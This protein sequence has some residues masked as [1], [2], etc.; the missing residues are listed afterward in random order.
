MYIKSGSLVT[1]KDSPVAHLNGKNVTLERYHL[2][3]PSPDNVHRITQSLTL[4]DL[5]DPTTRRLIINNTTITEEDLSSKSGEPPPDWVPLVIS[6][7][8]RLPPPTF[9]QFHGV[10]SSGEMIIFPD[11]PSEYFTEVKPGVTV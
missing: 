10:F 2:V 5:E 1:K 7:A 9:P 3:N 11:V 6:V 4:Y 8:K